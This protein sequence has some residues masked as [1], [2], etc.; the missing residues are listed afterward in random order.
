MKCPCC[1]EFVIND[2]LQLK[3]YHAQHGVNGIGGDGFDFNS[4]YRCEKHNKAVGGSETSSHLKGL[5]VD[6]KI[7]NSTHRF[8]VLQALIKA[9]FTR[10]GIGKTFIHADIDMS[11][12]QNLIWLYK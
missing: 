8:L 4:W 3:L 12:S 9:G 5:A 6:I 11:K 10:I 1:G 2:E 7:H